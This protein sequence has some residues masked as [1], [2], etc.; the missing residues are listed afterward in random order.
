MKPPRKRRRGPLGV[1][2][3]VGFAALLVACGSRTG[4][5][6]EA[7]VDDGFTILPDGGRVPRDGGTLTDGAAFDAPPLIDA[8]PRDASRLDCPDAEATLIYVVTGN[9]ELY[10]F[11]PPD[12]TFTFISNIACPA[13]ADSQGGP[14]TPFSMAVD[15]RGVAPV[16]FTDNRL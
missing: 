5:F 8:A 13:G 9:N 14:A 15:R 11:Y 10:S 12:S 2:A 1:L 4:L 3:R 6:G 16:L 7:A